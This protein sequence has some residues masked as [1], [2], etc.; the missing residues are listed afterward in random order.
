MMTDYYY[1][2]IDDDVYYFYILKGMST[3]HEVTVAKHCGLRVVGMSLISNEAVASY[4]AQQ[5]AC[6]DEVLATAQNRAQILE[7]IVSIV[8]SRM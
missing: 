1:Y 2:Y 7:K 4:D 6:H 8:V 5:F 3:C